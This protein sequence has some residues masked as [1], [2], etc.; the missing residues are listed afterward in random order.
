[1][2]LLPPLLPTDAVDLQTLAP[3]CHTDAEAEL[4]LA[5]AAVTPAGVEAHV[6]KRRD[7]HMDG[8]GT[9]VHV[10]EGGAA[11]AVAHVAEEMGEMW[12]SRWE[13]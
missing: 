13:F 8:G 6:G 3:S 11:G 7:S 9:V 10:D 5:N 2:P 12:E 4:L 1:M